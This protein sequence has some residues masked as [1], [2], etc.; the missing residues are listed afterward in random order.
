MSGQPSDSDALSENPTQTPEKVVASPSGKTTDFGTPR[1][2]RFSGRT[3]TPKDP[4]Y[5]KQMKKETDDQYRILK[6]DEFMEEFVPGDD[7]PQDSPH[8]QAAI[9]ILTDGLNAHDFDK[10]PPKEAVLYPTF[11]GLNACIAAYSNDRFPSAQPSRKH[12]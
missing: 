9:R 10:K 7:L 6:Y 2:L 12:S 5:L 3:T 1:R 4:D 8:M 11:V